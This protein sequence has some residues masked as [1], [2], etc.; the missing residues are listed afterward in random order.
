MTGVDEDLYESVVEVLNQQIRPLLHIHGGEARVA[1]V[2]A[3]TGTVELEML[4][5]CA[6]CALVPWT[7][8]ALLRTRLTTIPGVVDVK[9]K[10]VNVS[11][12]AVRRMTSLFEPRAPEATGKP[13]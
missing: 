11:E 2:S 12:V 9:V 1:R 4:G 5:S 13:T 10:G 8:A 3:E 7:Y 6:C